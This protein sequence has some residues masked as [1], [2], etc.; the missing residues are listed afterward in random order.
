MQAPP[1]NFEP[2]ELFYLI[3]VVGSIELC[4]APFMIVFPVM[5]THFPHHLMHLHTH[6]VHS[7]YGLMHFHHHPLM[8]AI[9]HRLIHAR[10]PLV[11]LH[12]VPIFQITSPPLLGFYLIVLGNLR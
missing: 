7:H 11:H 2:A 3:R 6:P 8:I 10:R 5:L 12:L 4:L 1:V 9:H